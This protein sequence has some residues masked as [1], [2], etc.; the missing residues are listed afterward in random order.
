[1][2]CAFIKCQKLCLGCGSRQ[3]IESELNSFMYPLIL[4]IG[5]ILQGMYI[6]RYFLNLLLI[7]DDD[8]I[9]SGWDLGFHTHYIKILSVFAPGIQS[10]CA[11][12]RSK[13]CSRAVVLSLCS[14]C[15][16]F[17]LCLLHCQVSCLWGFL[18]SRYSV[19][20]ISE[21]SLVWKSVWSYE[22]YPGFS[23]W[24]SFTQQV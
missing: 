14:I 23:F 1:M 8:N 15:Q 21:T 24:Y 16:Q 4:W 18:P 9:Y 5:I 11:G 17:C 7:L 10:T 19:C 22:F 6:A 20:H 13:P 12:H 3:M 2:W